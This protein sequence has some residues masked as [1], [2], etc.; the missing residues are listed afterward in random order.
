[1]NYGKYLGGLYVLLCLLYS[2][3]LQA[4]LRYD[5]SLQEYS[6]IK[7]QELLENI[8]NLSRDELFHLMLLAD[9]SFIKE[10]EAKK[11]LAEFKGIAQNYNT[12]KY[13]KGDPTKAALKIYNALL[14]K[15]YKGHDP[16]TD[17]T[18]ITS[19]GK[20][21][22]GSFM[23]L[24]AF[25]FEE[26]NINTKFYTDE[27]GFHMLLYPET[28]NYHV[29]LSDFEQQSNTEVMQLSEFLKEFADKGNLSPLYSV[30]SMQANTIAKKG[31]FWKKMVCLQYMYTGAQQA[32]KGLIEDAFQSF[33]KS[34]SIIPSTNAY[35]QLFS[36]CISEMSVKTDLSDFWESKEKWMLL[37]NNYTSIADHN[38]VV[39]FE[40]ECGDE[41]AKSSGLEASKKKFDY[42]STALKDEEVQR[43]IDFTY[44][45]FLAYHRVYTKNSRNYIGP[46]KIAQSIYPEHVRLKELP[47]HGMLNYVKDLVSTDIYDTIQVLVTLLPEI[48]EHPQFQLTQYRSC[49]IKC[50][51]LLEVSKV[52]ELA[53]YY[54]KLKETGC[55]DQA[56]TPLTN[57]FFADYSAYYVRQN[58]LSKGRNILLEG[59]KF[60]K[61][62]ELDDATLQ[63]R[64]K[65]IKDV[66]SLR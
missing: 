52:T 14:K 39:L 47:F 55:P 34:Y 66:K 26:L 44:N 3:A 2:G 15:Y 23:V 49:L 11:V 29:K 64:Y 5:P 58:N 54:G 9:N 18:S 40:Q 36:C 56:L 37:I 35:I 27:S 51:Y 4:Q 53:S 65:Y 10:Y 12:K 62:C 1:M 16:E 17:I 32:S 59:I 22:M 38:L 61:T 6:S 33:L 30:D 8:D 31:A 21:A 46:L 60:L 13:Q 19:S 24:I 7:E 63:S 25:V 50:Y 41:T 20:T 28:T 42:L 57:N 45:S 43:D 48:T